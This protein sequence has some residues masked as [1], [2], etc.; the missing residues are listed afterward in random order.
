M[1]IVCDTNILVRAA[2]NPNR[3]AGELLKRIRAGHVLVASL[4]LLAEVLE[5]LRRPKI[6]ALHRQDERGIRRYVSALYK[7]AAVVI[8]PQSVPRIVPHDPKDDAVLLT[9]V[10]GR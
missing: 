7:A 10:G 4:P 2:I 1:R 8:V 3:L 5:V 9:A 6:Q